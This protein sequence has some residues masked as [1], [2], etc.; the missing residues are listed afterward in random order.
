MPTIGHRPA[1]YA[2]QYT[3]S[4]DQSKEETADGDIQTASPEAKEIGHTVAA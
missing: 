1:K 2:D 4:L 3:H